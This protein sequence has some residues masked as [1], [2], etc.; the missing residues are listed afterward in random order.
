[1]LD[2]IGLRSRGGSIAAEVL[3]DWH[4]VRRYMA[5]DAEDDPSLRA[6]VIHEWLVADYGFD[7]HHARVK[8]YVAEGRE[9]IAV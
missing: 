6:S 4:T 9:R 7:G 2:V 5:A 1:V 3:L 8:L